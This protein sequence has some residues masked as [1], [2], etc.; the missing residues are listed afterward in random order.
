MASGIERDRLLS[1]D[2]FRGLTIASMVLVNNPG[3]WANIYAPLRHATWN[4]WTFTD[5]IFPFFLFISG[6]SMSLSVQRAQDVG[7]STSWL[8][9]RLQRRAMT[10]ILLG[11]ALNFVPSFDWATLRWPGVLQRIGLC[12]ALATP[13]VLF[14]GWRGQVLLIVALLATYSAVMLGVPVTDVNGQT[15]TGALEPGRDV[16]AYLDRLLMSGHLWTQSRIW[17]PEGLL[18]TIP[19]LASVLFGTLTGRWIMLKIVAAE[20][21]V[22]MMLAG[23]LALWLGVVLDAALMPINKSLWTPS[24]CVF[25]TGWALLIFSVCY[26]LLDACGDE[27][28]RRVSAKLSRPMLIYGV[29][30]LFIFAFSGLVARLLGYIRFESASGSPVSARQWLSQH[31]AQL[32]LAPVDAS[33]LHAILFNLAMFAVAWLLWR[34]KIF[35]KV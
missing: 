10:I 3:D 28:I 20:K 19:A 9:W 12:A 2:V 6:V 5:W 26:W 18:G 35:I 17:D 34:R 25:M 16:G 4:G 14:I 1:L 23:L 31:L 30:A 8:F 33:L 21:T 7:A 24:Y 27:R 11:L 22:W 15:V 29:N 32:P 13:A